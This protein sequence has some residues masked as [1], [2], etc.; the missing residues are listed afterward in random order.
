MA[1]YGDWLNLPPAFGAV[2]A[3]FAHSEM[4]T[5]ELQGWVVL[6]G[7]I[8]GVVDPINAVQ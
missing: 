7:G 1:C 5:R 3:G 2:T 8:D 4:I 6:P